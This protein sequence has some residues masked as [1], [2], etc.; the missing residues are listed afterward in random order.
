MQLVL[1]SLG[2][3]LKKRNDCF[4][5]IHKEESRLISPKRVSSIAITQ[6]CLVSSE[7]IKLAITHEVPLFIMDKFGQVLGQFWSAGYK[8]IRRIRRRQLALCHNTRGT[9][10][11][12]RLLRL[13]TDHQISNLKYLKNR[14]VR[15]AD[16]IDDCMTKMQTHLKKADTCAGK[17]PDECRGTLLGLEGAIARNYWSIVSEAM[18]SKYH[19]TKRTYRPAEDEFNAAL[20]YLYGML[21]AVVESAVISAGFD[22]Q[23]GLMHCDSYNKPTFVYDLIEPFRPWMDRILMDLCLQ[24]KLTDRHFQHHEKEGWWLHHEGKKIVIPS[25]NQFFAKRKVFQGLRLSAKHHIYHFI[26]QLAKEIK[27]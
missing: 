24:K 19:F 26:G 13:K 18:P 7:A 15:C 25:T 2:L 21:Y 23:C 10:I 14:K 16:A 12:L 11:I 3:V 20:N 6:A 27:A 1:D 8:K 5:V 9:E 22:N 17:E 4:Q